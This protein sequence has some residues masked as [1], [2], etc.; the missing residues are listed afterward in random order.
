MIACVLWPMAPTWLINVATR[1]H[2]PG[3]TRSRAPPTPTGAAALAAIPLLST[4]PLTALPFVAAALAHRVG[5][6]CAA[7]AAGTRQ[8]GARH[9]TCCLC[10]ASSMRNACS[11]AYN[12]SALH[13]IANVRAFRPPQCMQTISPRYP[14]QT[15][16][17]RRLVLQCMQRRTSALRPHP[18]SCALQLL[19]SVASPASSAV[20]LGVIASYACAGCGQEKSA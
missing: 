3:P 14:L 10:P 4:P 18:Y 9:G 13:R 16:R 7:A 1:R 17:H 6:V 5:G 8:G 12:C 11:P 20:L 19:Q 2:F 15:W